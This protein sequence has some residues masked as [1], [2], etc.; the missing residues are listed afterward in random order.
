MTGFPAR[1][2]FRPAEAHRV[3]VRLRVGEVRGA[4]HRLAAA[5]V[6]ALE[7]RRD[8]RLLDAHRGV[9]GISRPPGAEHPRHPP[10]RI[11]LEHRAGRLG[12]RDVAPAVVDE[13]VHRGVPR[14]ESRHQPAQVSRVGIPTAPVMMMMMM[15]MM[16]I[17]RRAVIGKGVRVRDGGRLGAV[18]RTTVRVAPFP[19]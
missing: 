18:H 15:M 2:T 1:V 11:N 12:R 5:G 13:P 9:A 19:R 4:E 3:R 16:M 6:T 8:G 14:A 10:R 7:R 17:L